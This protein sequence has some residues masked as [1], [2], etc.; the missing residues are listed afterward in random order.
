MILY[1]NLYL[2]N[3]FTK[4]GNFPANYN[5]VDLDRATICNIQPGAILLQT[6]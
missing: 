3:I 2:F 6:W 5:V 1:N 4:Q